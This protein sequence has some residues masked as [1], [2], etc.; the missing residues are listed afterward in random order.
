MPAQ[1]DE[2]V[3]ELID[4]KEW[5]A[6]CHGAERVGAS[7]EISVIRSDN[8]HCY[9][10]WGWDG[11]AKFVISKSNDNKHIPKEAYVMTLKGCMKAAEDIDAYMNARDKAG[12]ITGKYLFRFHRGSLEESMKT[13]VS[14]NDIEELRKILW[15]VY[16]PGELVMEKR[17]YDDRADWHTWIVTLNGNAVGF[18][19]GKP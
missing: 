8:T 2:K 13:V 4:R 19:N 10:S 1:I 15:E 5:V 12:Q 18:S 3:Q 11:E 14:F 16:G 6:I 17:G 7:W 9:T